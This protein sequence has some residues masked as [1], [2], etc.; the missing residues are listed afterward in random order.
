MRTAACTIIAKNYLPFARVL[1]SSLHVSSPDILRIVIL[2]DRPAG[3]FDPA[4]EDFE[5][6]LSESLPIPDS[7]WFHFKY[8]ILELSTAVKPFAL[9][10][11]LEHYGV[12]QVLFFDP[13]IVIY[14]DLQVLMRALDDSSIILTPHLTSPLTDE[15]R[16][17]DLEILRSGA[18][19]LG[20][21]GIRRC[22]ET[23]RFLQW[24]KTRLYDHC[25]VDL[26]KGLFVDQRWIDLVPG[27]FGGVRILRN[28]GLNVAYW[29]LSH[30]AVVR[31]P[32]GYLANGEP[33]CFF[34]FSGFNPDEPHG[35]S[36]HQNRFTLDNLGEVRELV[37]EYRN[38]LYER[39]YCEC[40]KWPYAFGSFRNGFPIPDM[41]RPAHHEL[42][43]VVARISDPFSEE[44]Y[45]AFVDLWNQPL[46]GPDGRPSGVT[47]LA[48]RIYRARTDVQQAMPDIF[49]G[50]LLRFLNWL[51]SS[52]RVE[53]KLS[54]VFVAPISKAIQSQ[55]RRE[56]PD[57]GRQSQVAPVVHEKVLAAVA[58][59]GIWV[60][61]ERNPV[62]VEALNVL[63]DKGD[64]RLR[65]SRLALAIY[66]SRPDVQ[67][68][69]PDP[70]GRDSVRFLLW[71][72]TYGAHEYRL[73]EVLLSPLKRQWNGVVGSLH[74]PL[75]R[76]W[77]RFVLQATAYSLEWRQ[78]ARRVRGRLRLMG[79]QAAPRLSGQ[80]APGGVKESL[81]IGNET[82]SVRIAA[83]R[84]IGANVIGYVRSEMGVGESVRC[85]IRAARASNLP[86]AVRS[87]DGNGPYRL[88][89]R[90]IAVIDSE[91]PHT[92]NLFHVNA[93]Q[94]E[95]VIG[96]LGLEF[97]RGKRNIGYWAWELEEF[98]DRWLPAFRFFDE[99]WT[100]STFCQSAISRKS[101][102]PVLRMPHAIQ[103][104]RQGTNSR[105]DFS[106]PADRFVFLAIC[107]LL[108]IPERKNPIGAI[109]AFRQAFGAS[110]NCHL[111]LKVSHGQERPQQMAAIIA[112]AADLP[113]AIID[114]TLERLQ[115][116]GLIGSC[117]CLLSL[118]RSEGFGLSLAE[119]MYLNK[120]VIATAYSGNTDFT[121]PDN[122]FLVEYDLVRVPR[123]CDPYDEGA[124]WADPRLDHA[125]NQMQ[126]VF[127][128]PELRGARS[129]RAGDYIRT[130]F[131]PEVVGNL[132]RERLELVLSRH[133]TAP[134]TVAGN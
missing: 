38:R 27:M 62:Q 101:P 19:N 45:R 91:F 95:N 102:V 116:N 124:V 34:H 8:T 17:T 74:N 37:L 83:S 72:L 59:T 12:D 48:Y 41:G 108:S 21:I 112:A 97:I 66:Q 20:F 36:R 23:A 68:F 70:C 109:K 69:F 4:H 18:Y 29:N 2:V 103:I 5:T 22:S 100:P 88:R 106:I 1:M 132:M 115:V 133:W 76:H 77:Y 110:R 67:R 57:P 52:G 44:G 123:G 32:R 120:P 46:S 104:E 7:A 105:A 53:H 33:L 75:Q 24:W 42:P 79:A 93:D 58:E 86:V 56:A 55:E 26:S 134:R 127:S 122:A 81:P 25:V 85:A 117:D 43:E 71:F 28:P 89:D 121:R 131:A 10:Y 80:R 49:G 82:G 114:R 63:I 54:D 47:R 84:S 107:D 51:L 130:H 50:D 87:V 118:H 15:Y 98:P 99:I 61:A 3:L 35:F 39:G 6:I 64:A 73:A 14:G 11:I 65:L 31:S 129:S 9:E 78:A 60:S 128:N 113:V 13:D 16:P 96:R 92:V 30:R 111:V 90:S 126:L 125:V 119:A 40:R 94:A